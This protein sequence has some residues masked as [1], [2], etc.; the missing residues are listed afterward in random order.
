MLANTHRIRVYQRQGKEYK[1]GA[2]DDDVVF[3]VPQPFTHLLK[4]PYE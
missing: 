1:W 3:V 4:L 2:D